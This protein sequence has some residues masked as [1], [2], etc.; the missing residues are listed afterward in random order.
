MFWLVTPSSATYMAA[1]KMDLCTLY[2][3]RRPVPGHRSIPDLPGQAHIRSGQEDGVHGEARFK[4]GHVDILVYVSR[5]RRWFEVLWDDLG[6]R[7]AVTLRHEDRSSG[8]SIWMR[9]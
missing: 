8:G 2:L 3:W 1:R 6:S 7:Q 9:A 5:R 4:R